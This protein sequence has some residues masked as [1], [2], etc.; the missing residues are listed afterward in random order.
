MR[1]DWD[2]DWDKQV[3]TSTWHHLSM[4]NWPGWDKGVEGNILS[5]ELVICRGLGRSGFK[6]SAEVDDWCE[7]QFYWR[8]FTSSSLPIVDEGEKY[9]SA[10][11][12]Q[13]TKDYL[14]FVDEYPQALDASAFA[15]KQLWREKAEQVVNES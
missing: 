1:D 3:S 8:D 15:L 4:D 11:Y 12:F 6:I 2:W 13:L 10:F 9:I 14:R 7:R 5:A